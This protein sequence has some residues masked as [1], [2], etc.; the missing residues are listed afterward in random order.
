MAG[1]DDDEK[2]VEVLSA[3]GEVLDPLGE[4]N[5]PK[6]VPKDLK[7]LAPPK[8]GSAAARGTGDLLQYYLAEIRRHP[9]L[10]PEEEKEAAVAWHEH[11]D[12]QAAERLVTANLRL[13][14][15]L[16]YQYHRQWSNVL[17]LIQEGNIGLV[18]AL[19]RYDPY[20]GIRFSSYAQY[21]IRAMILRYLM[22]NYRMVR[23]GSTRHGRKLFFQLNK[24]KQRLI[25]EGLKPS[26]KLLA[27]RLEVPEQEV[28]NVDQHLRAPAMSFD[29]PLGS[30]ADGRALKDVVTDEGAASLDDTVA[31]REIGAQVREALDAFA[32][33]L[34][35]EREQ[36]IWD[37]RVRAHDPIPLSQLGTRFGVS[38]ERIRQ[39]EAR[40]R[41]RVKAFL[42]AE[43]GDQI[44]VEFDVGD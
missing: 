20:R 7:L 2:D 11:G 37:E 40:M 42:E 28:I 27:E 41:K 32:E 23:L 21:W 16:A 5:E 18:E 31:R 15:K 19:R 30:E 17:D 24:E 38:K 36:A 4:D 22:D 26:T 12:R 33:T 9:L 34:V 10:S 44:Y 29:A 25:D 14:V 39:I 6:A 8:R 35:D 1:N 13:V 3:D 43:L